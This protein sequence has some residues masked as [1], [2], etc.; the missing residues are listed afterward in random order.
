[1]KWNDAAL[2]QGIRDTIG[3][4]EGDILLSDVWEMKQLDLENAGISDISAL[5]ELTNLE[6]LSLSGNN[7]ENADALAPLI[8]LRELKLNDNQLSDFWKI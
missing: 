1:M 8:N 5:A 2:E 6:Y 7:L 3:I 4:P